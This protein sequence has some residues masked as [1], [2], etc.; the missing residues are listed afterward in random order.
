MFRSP[1]L[2]AMCNKGIVKVKLVTACQVV[3]STNTLDTESV[4]TSAPARRVVE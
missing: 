4:C 1:V 3:A 2:V